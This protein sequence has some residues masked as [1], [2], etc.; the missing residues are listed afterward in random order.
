[1][2]VELGDN[3]WIYRRNACG[4][5]WEAMT[6]EEAFSSTLPVHTCPK[7]PQPSQNA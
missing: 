7:E 5:E 3:R 2:L 1:M 6:R 4:K